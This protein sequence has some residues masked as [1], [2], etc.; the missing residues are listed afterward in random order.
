[1]EKI[2]IKA[3]SLPELARLTI[4]EFVR[5]R[6][7][8]YLEESC[9]P[10]FQNQS[11]GTF[12]TLYKNG[13]LRGCIGTISP[14]QTNI[15]HEVI[16]NAIS[17]STHDPRFHP[18][19]E[20]ELPFIKYS[21]NVLMPAEPID[22]ENELDPNKYGVIVTAPPNRRGLLLPRLEGINTVKD[23]LYHAKMKA[24]IAPTETVQLFRFES[25]EHKE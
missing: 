11:A 25:I 22:S 15:V 6:K 3:N 12:V 20:H 1:M 4:E 13:Q 19:E 21:V 9:L 24:G 8:V 10:E 17:S 2:T 18:V 5:N 23:Q 16:R 14:V 7:V